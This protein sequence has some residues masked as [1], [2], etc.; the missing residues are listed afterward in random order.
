M[1]LRDECFSAIIEVT[2]EWLIS[3]VRSHVGLQVASL[4]KLAHTAGVRAE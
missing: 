1:A 3:C 4:L 2:F